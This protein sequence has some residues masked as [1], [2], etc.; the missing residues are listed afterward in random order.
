MS[1]QEQGRTTLETQVDEAWVPD[2]HEDAWIAGHLA[3]GIYLCR[4]KAGSFM[5]I[6]KRVLQ[7]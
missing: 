4:M 7:K 3:S 6:R 5:K 2:E 1:E